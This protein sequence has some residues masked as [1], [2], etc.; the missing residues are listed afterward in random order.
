MAPVQSLR[1]ESEQ[2]AR[3]LG[4]PKPGSFDDIKLVGRIKLG[5]PA[6][7]AA[8][9]AQVIDPVGAHLKAYDL[10]SKSTLH[11]READAKPLSTDDSETLWQ[12]ARVYV[13]ALRHYHEPEAA[14]A[15]L[16]RAHPLLGGQRP[17]DL[18]RETTAGADL[19]LKVLAQAEAGVAV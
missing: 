8:A 3:I 13:E 18:A 9:V 5:I 12:V 10:V 4:L 2:I 1:P 14:S 11:R 19:V 6:H 7:S 15:F 17:M 16:F